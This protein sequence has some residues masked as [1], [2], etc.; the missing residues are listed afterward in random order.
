MIR[1][2]PRSTLFPYTTLFRSRRAI[3]RTGRGA[4]AADPDRHRPDSFG[5]LGA[6]DERE[7]LRGDDPGPHRGSARTRW[8]PERRRQK[9]MRRASATALGDSRRGARARVS[10]GAPFRATPHA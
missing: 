1:R 8:R 4:E 3:A 7:A 2:P 6:L 5:A 9:N 10:A